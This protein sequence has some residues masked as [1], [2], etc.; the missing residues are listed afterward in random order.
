MAQDE[1]AKSTA[2]VLR[3]HWVVKASGW[4]IPGL[5]A[6]SFSSQSLLKGENAGVTQNAYYA[7]DE[8]Q[9]DLEVYALDAGQNLEIKSISC[10]VDS[11]YSFE[12]NG[13][14]FSYAEYLVPVGKAPEGA[15]IYYG[16]MHT[17]Y[18]TDEDR[19]GTLKQEAVSWSF[20]NCQ[21]G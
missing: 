17:V 21:C 6:F 5:D 7:N 8:P 2:Q 15:R 14:I 4:Q 9:I 18:F 12:V 20:Q 11:L 16:A 1:V 13:Q 19:D 3:L 10:V